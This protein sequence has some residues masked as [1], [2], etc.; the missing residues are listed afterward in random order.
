MRNWG[1][2]LFFIRSISWNNCDDGFDT[3]CGSSLLEDNRSL[4]NG[5]TG[6]MGYKMFRNVQNMIYRGNVAYGNQG[7]GFELR[8]DTNSFLKVFNNT[9]VKNV[10]YGF[11]SAGIDATSVM[12]STNNVAAFNGQADWGNAQAPIGERTATM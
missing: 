5:P 9:S 2:N 4:F 7:R 8:Y 12:Y 6:T 10:Q 11:W 3:S 1:T